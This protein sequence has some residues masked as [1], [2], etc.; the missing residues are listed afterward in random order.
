MDRLRIENMRL[1]ALFPLVKT[2][3]FQARIGHGH[4]GIGHAVANQ[5]FAGY[6]VQ[7][8]AADARNCSRKIAVGYFFVQSQTLKQLRSLVRLQRGNAHFREYFE[9]FFV[10]RFGII[11]EQFLVGKFA[12]NHVFAIHL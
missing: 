1:A 5:H 3:H 9:Q 2:T 6:F 8:H 12:T 4:F 11:V 10:E 7:T